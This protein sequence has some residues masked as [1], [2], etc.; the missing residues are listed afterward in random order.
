MSDDRKS[1][2]LENAMIR[3]YGPGTRVKVEG[4]DVYMVKPGADHVEHYVLSHAS[5]EILD[6]AVERG[7]PLEGGGSEMLLLAPEDDSGE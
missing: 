7:V 6:A 1:K 2:T 4:A 5:A 3:R